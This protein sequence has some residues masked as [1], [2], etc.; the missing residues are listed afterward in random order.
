MVAAYRMPKSCLQMIAAKDYDKEILVEDE[1]GDDDL[2]EGA[3]T[4]PDVAVHDVREQ[5]EAAPEEEG[6]INLE[7]LFEDV[8][9]EDTHPESPE[10]EQEGGFPTGK[11]ERVDDL[12][13]KVAELSQPPEM[14]T[15][16]LSRPMRRRTGQAALVAIQELVLQLRRAG[17]PV[18]NLHSDRAR[19]FGTAQLRGWLSDQQISQTKTSG[20]EPA[21]AGNATAELGVKWYKSRTR[22]PSEPPGHLQW[23]GRWLQL[24]HRHHC[25][26]RPF[27]AHHYTEEEWRLLARSYGTRQKATKATRHRRQQG[28]A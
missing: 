20:G 4:T 7:A 25:G 22:A 28:P 2:M 8:L 9:N 21:A 14:A 6:D 1:E 24:M 17:L 15:I 19:E 13:T 18:N 10:E 23:I 27:L 16:Y 26:R 3:P 11:E 12:D 5:E